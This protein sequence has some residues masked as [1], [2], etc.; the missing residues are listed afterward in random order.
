MT[1]AVHW[2]LGEWRRVAFR[3]DPPDGDIGV[4][5]ADRALSICSR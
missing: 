4:P 2:E 1:I 5:A 3:V